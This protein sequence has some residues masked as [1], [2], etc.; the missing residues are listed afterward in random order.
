MKLDKKLLAKC[1][2]VPLLA[3]S[4]AGI[5]TMGGMRAFGELNQPPLS[6][7]AWLFPVVWTILYIL[8]G[9]ASYLIC[10]S[11]E[12]GKKISEALI[13]YEAQLLVN[14]LWPTFFFN[15]QWYLFSFFWLL[16]LWILV[17]ITRK[18]FQKL[19]KVAG[20]LLVPYLLWLTFAAY[21][22]IGVWWLN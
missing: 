3:G 6:P 4:I 7:P 15:Y 10:V 2:A 13:Y 22:N 9:V 5:M 19:S 17:F 12:D 1:I 14:F 8:M 20:Y 21:L 11:G 16:F 18:Q